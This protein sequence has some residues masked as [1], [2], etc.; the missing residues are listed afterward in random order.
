M[1]EINLNTIAQIIMTGIF[2]GVLT[3][4]DLDKTF[5]V[6]SNARRKLTL[7]CWWWSFILINAV[8]ACIAYVALYRAETLIN[9]NEWL[10]PIIVAG[11]YLTLIR[12]KITTFDFQGKDVPFGFEL[13]YEGTKAYVYKRINS[14]ARAAR[15]EE[16]STLARGSNWLI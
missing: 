4:F 9:I 13:F 2:A 10:Q 14:I 8:I 6:P 11:I 1:P 12:T 3:L 5:Y 15:F 16:T 7:M